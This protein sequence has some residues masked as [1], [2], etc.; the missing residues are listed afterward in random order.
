MSGSDNKSHR[1][2]AVN[3]ILDALQS[4]STERVAEVYRLVHPGD[5]ELAFERLNEAERMAILESLPVD[6]FAEWSDYLTPSEL[7]T[8]FLKI[9]DRD[10]KELLD[11]LSDDE[12]VDFLQEIEDKDRQRY[13]ELLPEEKRQVSEELL[14]YPEESAG[15]RMTTM[16]ASVFEGITV[17]EALDQLKEISEEAELLSRIFVLNPSGQLVGRIRL[18]DLAFAKWETPI[19]DITSRDQLT[20]NALADQEEAAQM[21][22]RYDLLALPVV[23]ENL[24]LLGVITHDDAIEI[25]EEESTED[26]ERQSGIGGDGGDLAY[27]QTPILVHFRRRFGWVVALAFLGLLSGIVLLKHEDVFKNFYVLALY[28]PMVVAA[29]GNTGSQSATMVIRAMALGQLGPSQFLQVIGT[30]LRI[31]ALIGIALGICVATQ[32]RFL[33][34][35]DVFGGVDLLSTAMVVGLALAAQIFTS[36]LIGASLP[37]LARMA[38]LDPAVVASPAIT[39]L[40]DVSG[41]VIYFTLAQIILSQP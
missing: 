13:I 11:S 4:G 8:Y 14:Q 32:V 26:I 37:I 40:V 33:V 16:F 5:I 24:R 39:T 9:G 10:R 31:G 35:S 23:D 1:P 7:E 41:S 15:G 12:L 38:K 29:G 36:T 22:S 17:K 25:L 20:I 34:P 18:R 30:E 6:V 28:L 3:D 21:I 27:M 19:S 2:Y